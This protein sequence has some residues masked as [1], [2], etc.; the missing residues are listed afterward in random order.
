MPFEWKCIHILRKI[1][2]RC[3]YQEELSSWKHKKSADKFLFLYWKKEFYIS[4]NFF[5]E[6]S[7]K[8]ADSDLCL[9]LTIITT[10][11][12]IFSKQEKDRFLELIN[13]HYNYPYNCLLFLQFNNF[14]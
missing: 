6:A 13:S 12:S 1:L 4:L 7:S 9:T 2:C 10:K 5:T 3:F 8:T 11:L 14:F